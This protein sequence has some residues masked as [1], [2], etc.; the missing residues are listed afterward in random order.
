[1]PAE[2]VYQQSKAISVIRPSTNSSANT[3]S[4]REYRHCQGM[5][6][7]SVMSRGSITLSH[8]RP[9]KPQKH[10]YLPLVRPPIDSHCP[11]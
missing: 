8:N 6:L 2:R 10:M 7:I 11:V 3:T 5:R 9:S 1:M 4:V